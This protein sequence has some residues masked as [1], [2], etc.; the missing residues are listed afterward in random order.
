MGRHLIILQDNKLA[1]AERRQIETYTIK[2]KVLDA[3]TLQPINDALVYEVRNSKT[4]YVNSYGNF[5]LNLPAK[6][7]SVAI[8][9]KSV[10]YRDTLLVF[11]AAENEKKLLLYP[12]EKPP[13]SISRQPELVEDVKLVQDLAPDD[14][15]FKANYFDDYPKRMAQISLVPGISSNRDFNGITENKFS[16]DVLAGYA[17]GVNA[18]EIGGLVNI[19]R[20][21]VKGFQLAGLGNIEGGKV[22]GVQIA[23]LW[24]NNRGRLKGVQLSGVGNVVRDE[25]KGV[26]VSGIHNYVHGQMRG[27]QLAGIHNYS[28]LDVSG[29]QFAGI[30][31]MTGGSMKTFQ[32]SGIANYGENVGGVQF[33]GL[34]NIV[35]DT[36]GGGQMAGLFNYGREVNN[37]QLAGLYNISAE[38]VGGAQIA[39]LLNYGKKVNGSQLALFNIADTV[40]GSSF[41]F[42][43]IIRKGRHSVELSADETGIVHFSIKTGAYGFYNIFRGGIRAGEPD[44]YDFGYGIGISS[45][46]RKKWN[47]HWELTVDQV[48]EKGILEAPNINAR[49]HFL[50][51]RN[52]T[53][54]VRL[55]FG[56]VLVGHVSS[57]KNSETNEFLTDISFYPFYSYQFDETQVE[58]W[59]GVTFGISFF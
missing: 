17:A 4:T 29:G 12:K 11:R 22:E 50:F 32:L 39:G 49:S 55:F 42:L 9:V 36:V 5:E 54:K 58:L 14:R 59:L 57:W 34:C 15:R 3:R 26:Q 10:H 30:I 27:Y 8:G 23:G 43:S 53:S 6:Y 45:A 41:G 21:F 2:G 24:N 31:N 20:M 33:A 18:V 44:T 40:S 13:E 47:F 38:K 7:E 52:F 1:S 19:D 46:T 51:Y 56:P 25:F 37:F 16:F 48:L 28:R 35:E